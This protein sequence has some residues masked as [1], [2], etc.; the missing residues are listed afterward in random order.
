MTSGLLLL[1]PT[2]NALAA[3][4]ETRWVPGVR[5]STVFPCYMV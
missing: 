3:V 4:L 5:L 1:L 2:L